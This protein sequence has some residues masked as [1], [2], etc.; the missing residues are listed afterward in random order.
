LWSG[1]L[2]LL[3]RSRYI[4]LSNIL[5]LI[6]GAKLLDLLS[7][8]YLFSRIVQTILIVIF[9]ASF[10]ITPAQQLYYQRGTGK[11]ISDLN[12]KISYLNIH[13]RIASNSLWGKSLYL[14]FYN[15]WKYYGVKG[16]LSNLQLERELENKLIDYYFVWEPFGK[17]N[18][19]VEKYEEITGGRIDGLR[20]YQI[21]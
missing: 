16:R 10:A 14:A 5:I 12:N 2:P 8:K 6:T 13:G 20:V 21:K 4:W 18:K 15:D 3:V 9:A 19:L 7:Q 11:D 1:Y 17:D